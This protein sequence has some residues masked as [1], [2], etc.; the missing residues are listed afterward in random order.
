[1][2]AFKKNTTSLFLH[3]VEKCSYLYNVEKIYLGSEYYSSWMLDQVNKDAQRRKHLGVPVVKG[4]Q[5]LPP[6]WNRVEVPPS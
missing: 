6:G 2:F 5:N 4:G 3:I 1:M